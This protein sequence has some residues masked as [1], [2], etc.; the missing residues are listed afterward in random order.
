VTTQY[1]NASSNLPEKIS[2]RFETRRCWTSPLSAYPPEF[3][4]STVNITDD[5]VLPSG[6]AA[7]GYAGELMFLDTAVALYTD[8]TPGA[9]P[10]NK[11]LLD[12]LA[13]Q[14][15]VDF[16]AWR[17]FQVDRTYKGVL[18][19]DMLGYYDKVIIDYFM[20]D[21]TTRV[22]GPPLEDSKL[23]NHWDPATGTS[24][25]DF[26]HGHTAVPWVEVYGP[27]ASCSSGH[28]TLSVYRLTIEAGR[29]VK[30]FV[31]T[32]TIT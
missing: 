7:T 11:D 31:R 24:C 15:A 27:P 18:A 3:Y 9:D 19:L 29:L 25:V 22:I 28:L 2:V 4:V 6:L 1:Y 14:V 13:K 5:G 16:Y 12:A 20:D 8:S 30:T 21:A 17:Y 23:L 32:E 26:S 10:S